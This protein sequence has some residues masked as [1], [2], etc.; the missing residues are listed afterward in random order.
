MGAVG[1]NAY[2]ELQSAYVTFMIT[3]TVIYGTFGHDAAA[4]LADVIA[5]AVYTEIDDRTAD[6]ALV[7]G[8]HIK[9]FV[10]C[11]WLAV[12]RFYAGGKGKERSR[13]QKAYTEKGK[14]YF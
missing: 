12:I 7:V 1:I 4:N 10:R 3:H 13:D 2:T 9:A 5:V 8:I 11:L 6:V 14:G